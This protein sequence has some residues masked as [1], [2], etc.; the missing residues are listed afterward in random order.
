MPAQRFLV[1]R[2]P[3][4][5]S[6]LLERSRA[7]PLRADLMQESRVGEGERVAVASLLVLRGLDSYERAQVLQELAARYRSVADVPSRLPDAASLHRLVVGLNVVQ[8]R[9]LGFLNKV[10]QE[11]GPPWSRIAQGS[12]EMWAPLP[13]GSDG[14]A[15]AARLQ[16]HYRAAG[17]DVQTRV[18]LPAAE[19]YEVWHLLRERCGDGA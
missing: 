3:A 16:A 13:E 9:G 10:R 6:F 19:D 2:L 8:A 5:G 4:D 18:A 12:Y 1:A 11:F 14:N 17:I 15:A 7:T